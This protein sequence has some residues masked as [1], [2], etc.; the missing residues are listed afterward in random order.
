MSEESQSVGETTIDMI[1][2]SQRHRLTLVVIEDE[3]LALLGR[4]WL[5]IMWKLTGLTSAI[6]PVIVMKSS[7]ILL[8]TFVLLPFILLLLVLLRD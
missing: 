3:G 4:Y 1:H 7:Q 5:G 6:H 8:S 2:Q